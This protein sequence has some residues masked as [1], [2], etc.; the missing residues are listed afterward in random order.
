MSAQY[1]FYSCFS[2]LLLLVMHFRTSKAKSRA[3]PR[4]KLSPRG[5]SKSRTSSTH[6]S[7]NRNSPDARNLPH[8]YSARSKSSMHNKANR[9]VPGQRRSATNF[10]SEHRTWQQRGGYDGYAL[11][12]TTTAAT[13]VSVTSFASTDCRSWR[14][15]GTRA[16]HDHHGSVAVR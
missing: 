14:L 5:S 11:Q 1:F 8:S 2:E 10:E 7:N 9:E 6:R 3:S 13:M 12:T 16:R 4:S 15:A